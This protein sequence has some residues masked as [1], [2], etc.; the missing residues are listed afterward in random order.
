MSSGARAALLAPGFALLVGCAAAPAAQPGP[1]PFQDGTY[2]MGTLLEV[3]LEGPDP[4]A[5]AS[6]R[7]AIFAEVSRL[8]GLLSTWREDSDVSRLNRFAGVQQAVDP[9]VAELLELSLRHAKATRGSFDV[10]VGPLVALW[11]RAGE[12]GTPPTSGEIA[13]TRARVGAERLRV[14]PGARAELPDGM[15][16]D[17]GGVAKGFAL[18]RVRPLARGTGVAAALLVFG[19]SSTLAIGAPSDSPAGWR[20]L[21]RAPDGG[22][23]GVITLRDGA[24]SV[25]GSLG[26]FHEIAGRRYGHVID[27]RSGLPLESAREALVVAPDATLAEALSKA[28][29]VLGEREGIEVVAGQPGCEGLLLDAD[30][31]RYATPG[32]ERATR[33]ERLAEGA[34]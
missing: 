10:T 22:F 26:Q 33:Y 18:D 9:A 15:A 31:S 29:L 27:P 12:L 5:L 2:A 20:L 6:V 30:G 8:D 24:L 13:A 16:L 11:T 4:V 14:G 28:L 17:V 23:D 3:T 25:S 21:A 7:D 19:Q 1:A 34:P 32:W